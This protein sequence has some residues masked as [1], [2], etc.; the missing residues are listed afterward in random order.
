MSKEKDR[1]YFI[2]YFTGINEEQKAT[3]GKIYMYVEDKGYVNENKVHK[4]I[5]ASFNIDEPFI[6]N[7]HELTESDFY[8]FIKNREEDDYSNISQTEFL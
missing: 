3:R 7:I 2:V 5:R 8:D 1:R 6:T 4:V